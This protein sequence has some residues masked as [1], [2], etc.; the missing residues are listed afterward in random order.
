MDGTF[1]SNPSIFMQLYTIH[2]KCNDEFVVQLWCLLPDKS[3]ATY[4]RL[5]RLLQQTAA[6]LNLQLQPTAVHVDFEQA[7]MQA[8]RTHSG[9]EP[10]GCLFHFSQSVLRHLQQSG[11]QV[12]YNTNAPPEVRKWV[13]RLIALA[14]VPPV[15]IDQVFQA[16]TTNAPNILGC[17]AMIQYVN[18]TYVDAN[19]L[20]QR[21]VWNCSA[22]GTE[23]RICV[24]GIT[25]LLMR[26]SE[27][28]AQTRSSSLI[29]CR[30]R[31]PT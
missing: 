14:L 25:I 22:R 28:V 12:A 19:T 7:V 15:R 10:S 4:D 8:I 20:F 2:V 18:H 30:N 6:Q 13:R 1:S 26:S 24:R 16:L 5:F 11:L 21:P 3:G 29:S 27:E 23:Q 17:Y 9:N 31:K